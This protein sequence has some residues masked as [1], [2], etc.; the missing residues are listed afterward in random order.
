M[1]SKSYDSHSEMSSGGGKMPPSQTNTSKFGDGHVPDKSFKSAGAMVKGT[2]L[3]N[4]GA[5]R[6]RKY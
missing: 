2:R 4:G 6:G 1:P 5:P 3:P